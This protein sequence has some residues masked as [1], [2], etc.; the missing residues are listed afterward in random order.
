MNDI[1]L[2]INTIETASSYHE[3]ISKLK[4]IRLKSAKS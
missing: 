4:N 1:E 2:G 3:S